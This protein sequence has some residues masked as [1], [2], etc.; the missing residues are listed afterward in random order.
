MGLEVTVEAH[1][2]IRLTTV[3]FWENR[4]NMLIA[5]HGAVKKNKMELVHV[6]EELLKAIYKNAK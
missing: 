2:R 5:I 3:A 6:D 1:F 4:Q